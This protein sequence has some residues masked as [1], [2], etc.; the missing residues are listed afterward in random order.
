MYPNP[1]TQTL[2][3]PICAQ[4]KTERLDIPFFVRSKV[5]L[6]RDYPQGGTGRQRLEGQVRVQGFI[7][8]RSG[9]QASSQGGNPVSCDHFGSE[10]LHVTGNFLQ[11]TVTWIITQ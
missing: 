4:V 9:L 1:D 6:D 7:K 8:V 10:T 5:D 2:I 3:P 11:H